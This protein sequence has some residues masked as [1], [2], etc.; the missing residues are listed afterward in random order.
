MT[1][2]QLSVARS[3]GNSAS[4]IQSCHPVQRYRLAHHLSFQGHIMVALD[5]PGSHSLGSLLTPSRAWEA[6]GHP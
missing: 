1:S 3:A 6:G 5:L 2:R 4:S